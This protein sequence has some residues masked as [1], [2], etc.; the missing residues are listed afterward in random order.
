MGRERIAQV[1]SRPSLRPVR[2]TRVHRCRFNHNPWN[3]DLRFLT[4]DGGEEVLG[5]NLKPLG[6]IHSFYSLIPLPTRGLS[7]HCVRVRYYT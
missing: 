6:P 1:L 4:P 2:A 3:L 5:E 7:R